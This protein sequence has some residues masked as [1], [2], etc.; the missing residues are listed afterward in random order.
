MRT[1]HTNISPAQWVAYDLEAWNQLTDVQKLALST[2]PDFFRRPDQVPPENYRYL[3]LT[4]GR[5]WGKTHAM[6]L[7]IQTEVA[8]GAATEIGISAQDLVRT[9]DVQVK[10]LIETAPIWNR[11]YHVKESVVWESG[12]IA[13]IFSP[14]AP[15]KPRGANLSH[16]WLTEVAHY[17]RTTGLKLFHNITTACRV[18]PARVLIDTTTHGRSNILDHLFALNVGDPKRYPIV[19]GETWQNPM[20][21]RDYLRE[22]Y[23]MYVGRTAREELWGEYLTELDGANW[24]RAW[25]VANRVEQ[26]PRLELKLMGVDPAESTR[27]D[28]DDT[29]LV[30]CGRDRAGHVF[31][32]TDQSGKH[33]P[34]SLARAILD[35]HRAGCTGAVV[36]TNRGGH[37]VLG[38]VR[39]YAQIDGISVNVL[40]ASAPWP[41]Y[42]RRTL[43]V[44][45]VHNRGAKYNRH[46]GA[47]S[48]AKQSRLHHV[49]TFSELEDV[50]CSYTGEGPSP[51]ALD[52]LSMVADDLA[53]LHVEHPNRA[54]QQADAQAVQRINRELVDVARRLRSKS[55]V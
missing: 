4:C 18:N 32:L 26:P 23:L 55:V 3:T 1:G 12:A 24:E 33:T 2:S 35:G 46:A 16:V 54:R 29:G 5:G 8:N 34:E 40:P 42:D 27:A 45:E 51:D 13:Y 41:A 7:E 21:T 38:V 50:M 52:A 53:G 19:R 10:A 20:L 49:G 22:Q 14:E 30:T 37:F 36:E 39:A 17:P 44:R 11:A 9:V 31:L 6:A 25:I 48:L 47:A 28:A 43:H 15:N